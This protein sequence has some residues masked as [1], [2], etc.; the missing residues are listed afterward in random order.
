MR[1]IK[2]THGFFAL[3]DDED[4]EFLNQWKWYVTLKRNT[5]Y[6]E[7][8][9]HKGKTRHLK[10]HRLILG[11]DDP[12]IQVD[13][14]DGNGLNNQRFNLRKATS[15]QNNFN[16]RSHKGST[17]KYL[18]VSWCN[19]RSKWTARIQTNRV[20]KCI[21]RFDNEKDAARAYNEYAI[22]LHKEFAS[23]NPV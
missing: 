6:A 22:L 23:L 4:Y 12:K 11:L 13:H 16:Q 14:K 20:L 21:G 9:L 2:L 3:V 10:M 15:G 1:K 18:G 19:T 17:S 8:S 5:Y 7:R